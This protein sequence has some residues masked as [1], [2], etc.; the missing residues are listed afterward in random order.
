MNS[1][2]PCQHCNKRFEFDLQYAGQLGACP[3]CGLETLFFVQK[4]LPKQ[5]EPNTA[6]IEKVLCEKDKIRKATE[7]KRARDTVNVIYNCSIIGAILGA[8]IGLICFSEDSIGSG[9][10]VI[11]G[12]V[13]SYF[14]MTIIREGLHAVFDI[15]DCA[16]LQNK[17]SQ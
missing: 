12:A 14:L 16:L 10:E 8:I 5:P 9:I 11:A 15:A 17:T 13:S 3:Y 7:Y 1:S 4:S 2:C 6:R